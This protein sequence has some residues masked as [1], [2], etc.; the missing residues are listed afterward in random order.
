MA[1]PSITGRWRITEMDLWDQDS[2]DLVGPGTIEFRRDQTG[3]LNFIA[4]EANLAF[5]SSEADRSRVEFTF[6]GFDEGDPVNGRGW[7]SLDN[8]A[9]LVGHL[10]F[11]MG[12]DS[13]FS[14]VRSD[15]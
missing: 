6:D 10:Y 8:D 15:S 3:H 14:A 11:H 1:K 9:T 13:G 12:D 2:I 4:I 5:R 7:A